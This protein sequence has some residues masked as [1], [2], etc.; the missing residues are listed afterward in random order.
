VGK[1]RL[2]REALALAEEQGFATALT[3]ASRAA[4]SIPLGAFAPLLPVSEFSLDGRVDIL[5]SAVRSI[6]ERGAG[7]PVAVGVDDAHL[8]DDLSATV[9][10]Q[11]AASDEACVVA[12]V[13]AGEGVP[14]A[15][16]NLW[17]D[18]SAERIELAALDQAE[19]EVLLTKVLGGLIDGAALHDLWQASQGN[20]LYLR[21]LVLG[22][23]EAGFLHP[24]GGIWR[25]TAKLKAFPRLVEL[26]EARLADLS[27]EERDVLELTAVAEHIGAGMLA[28]LAQAPAVAAVERKGLLTVDRDGRRHRARLA[29]PLHGDVLRAQMPAIQR[30]SVQRLLADA[31]EAVEARRREDVLQAALWRLEAGGPARPGL[32]LNGARKALFAHDQQLA[33][34][35]ARAAIEAG[36]GPKARIVLARALQWQMRGEEA[37]GALEP[38]A[39]TDM[40]QEELTEAALTRA[41][42]L[43]FFF[44]RET[45]AEE[46]LLQTEERLADED[47]RDDLT[48]LRATVHLYCSR[49]RLAA[50]AAEQVVSRPAGPR[51]GLVR[52]V[53]VGVPAWAVSGRADDAVTYSES[54]MEMAKTLEEEVP[55]VFLQGGGVVALRLAGRLGECLAVAEREYASAIAR[56]DRDAQAPMAAARGFAELTIGRV[57]SAA[58]WFREGA[59]LLRELDPV[60]HL[61]LCLG[62]LVQAMALQGD[63]ADADNLI[64]EAEQRAFRV[65]GMEIELGKVWAAAARGD[66]PQARELALQAAAEAQATGQSSYEAVLLHDVVRLGDPVAVADR[67]LQLAATIQGALVPVYAAHA[68]ALIGGD[69]TALDEVS[70]SFEELGAL[71][72]AAESTAEAAAAY[73]RAGEPRRSARSS[74]WALALAEACEGVRTP[75]LA[76][77]SQPP[78]LTQREREIALLAASGA[79]SKEIAEQLVLSV[80]T[81]QNHLQRA[82]EK[83]GLTSRKELAEALDRPAPAGAVE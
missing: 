54:F 80:R 56:R 39:E 10:Q 44:A 38:L 53:L 16:V 26:I 29:H 14:D 51:R 57:G 75:A 46:V 28:T 49:F 76:Q 43:L 12:T 32:L 68:E 81:I 37:L 40:S 41:E 34:R 79:A 20:V 15:V 48:G 42:T 50:A 31:V 7:R 11:L 72:L 23:H 64:A 52:A 22:A 60:G 47:L 45:D 77:A 5:Q 24:D 3:T 55:F 1:S 4:A 65:L 71:L 18:E 21:E 35:L 25:L 13:R 33:E 36:A 63:T 83:L 2:A 78:S 17:K 73:R 69:G 30:L 67:L 6:A 58:R 70:A 27:A 74:R 8:L 61:P 9:V 19:T 82:Y 59:M 62:G 66:L